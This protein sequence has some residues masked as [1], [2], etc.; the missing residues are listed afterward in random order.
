MKSISYGPIKVFSCNANRELAADIARKLGSPLGLAEVGKFP[1]GEINLVVGETVRGSDVFII[2]PTSPPVNDN[3]MELLIMIDAFKRASA[4]R[5]TAVIPYFGYARQDRK[6]RARDPI[7]AKLVANLITVAGPD[8]VLTLDLHCSQIEGFFDIPV[9][10]LVGAP[11]LAQY[12]SEKFENMKNVTVVSPDFGGVGR[13]RRLARKLDVPIA[14][15]DKRRPKDAV[16][17]VI[18]LIGDVEGRDVI[19]ID[20]QIQTGGSIVNAAEAL[21]LNGANTIYA[22]CS[23]AILADQAAELIQASCIDE[24][25]TLNTVKLTGKKL[26]PKARVLDVSP[27]F[28]EAISRIHEGLAVSVLF[29]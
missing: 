26:I 29:N 7:S 6:T 16:S 3:L 18:S 17:E 20:E 14:I 27:L 28:A 23:H 11:I 25:V 1:D 2:Q 13:A 12:Y 10:H 5:I 9:D 4:G 19:L 21:K 15:I 22:C 8:R 24:L